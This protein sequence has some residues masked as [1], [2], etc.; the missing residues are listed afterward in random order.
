MFE[1]FVRW[2]SPNDWIPGPETEREKEELRKMETE[3]QQLKNK[4][5]L[6]HLSISLLFVHQHMR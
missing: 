3:Y 6:F 1:D 5:E 4:G 2:Y